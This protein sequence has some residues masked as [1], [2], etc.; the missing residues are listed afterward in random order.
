M[1]RIFRILAFVLFSFSSIAQNET[2][3]PYSRFGLGDLQSFSTANH[4]ALGGVG[5]AIYDPLS[6][7]ISNPASYSSVYSQRFTMQTGG[8]HTTKLLQTS[9]Q[10]QLVN[11]TK[12]NYLMFSFPLSKFWG[13]SVGMLPFSEMS[14]SFSDVST[15]P[16][17]NLMFEGNGGITRFYFGT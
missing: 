8:L 12:F 5:I 16:D 7:N 13:T 11:S 1:S 9:S 15:D 6:I 10:D 17:A 3:S 14:Y 2:N 4:S